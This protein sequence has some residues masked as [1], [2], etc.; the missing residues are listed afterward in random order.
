MTK[1]MDYSDILIDMIEQSLSIVTRFESMLGRLTLSKTLWKCGFHPTLQSTIVVLF[2]IQIMVLYNLSF[3]I[4][5]FRNKLY[6]LSLIATFWAACL[7]NFVY[8]HL[9]PRFTTAPSVSSI[10]L[11]GCTLNFFQPK[12]GHHII[13]KMFMG[14]I[15][16]RID[17]WYVGPTL[18]TNFLS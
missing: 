2:N 16:F 7:L 3:E 14:N 1:Y 13:G 17:Y 11:R 8:L 6:K 12:V 18:E 10:Y 4:E 9:G 5:S 15:N